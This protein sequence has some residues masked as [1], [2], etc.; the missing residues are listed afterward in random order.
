MLP[1]EQFP[2]VPYRLSVDVPL[3]SV[4]EDSVPAVT[5]NAYA[6]TVL[7]PRFRV[8]VDAPDVTRNPFP[9]DSVKL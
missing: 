2:P 5:V 7:E 9:V 1:K 8:L 6:V 4:K 3:F